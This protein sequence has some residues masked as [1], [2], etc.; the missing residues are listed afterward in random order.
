MEALPP[1]LV[2]VIVPVYNGEKYLDQCLGSLLGQTLKEMEVICVN[3]GSTDSSLEILERTAAIDPRLKIVTQDNRGIGPARSRGLSLASAP[4]IGFAD[5]DDWVEPETYQTATA[6]ALAD[7]EV[8]L[9]LWGLRNIVIREG[10]NDEF[11]RKIKPTW[12]DRDRGKRTL[13]GPRKLKITK[14]IWS[15][16]F[17]AAVIKEQGVDF[18][19]IDGDDISFVLKYLAHAKY[20]YFLK[21]CFYN[22]RIHQGSGMNPS[23]G[24][25]VERPCFIHQA[26]PDILAY[27]RERGL[28]KAHETFLADMLAD[29]CGRGYEQSLDP[30]LALAE[31]LR[32]AE[33]YE[34]PERPYGLLSNLRQG[35]PPFLPKRNWLEKIASVKNQADRKVFCFLGFKFSVRRSGRP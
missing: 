14:S 13:T 22:Y 4:Y 25:R 21:D 17:K 15:K 30:G 23:R 19:D 32:L 9:V 18:A 11:A 6:I 24:K 8:D 34:L 5:Q 1:P 7:P 3:D 20:G 10:L 31:G 27:Y 33:E 12:I 16:L 2:S 35:R 28:I 26:A 29:A